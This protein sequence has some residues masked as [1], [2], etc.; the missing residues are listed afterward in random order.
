M[1]FNG[2]YVPNSVF[3]SCVHSSKICWISFTRVHSPRS[4]DNVHSIMG[5]WKGMTFDAGLVSTGKELVAVAAIRR[6]E[7]GG[8]DETDVKREGT[9][10]I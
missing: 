10:H 1:A 7:G 2:E 4:R 8:A 6:G 9:R 3:L 5:A